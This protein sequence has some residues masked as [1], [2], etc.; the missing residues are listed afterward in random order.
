[1]FLVLLVVTVFLASVAMSLALAHVLELPGKM[2]LNKETYIAVQSIYYPGFTIGGLGE[3]V[4][5]L[6][7]LGLLLMTPAK[8]TAFWCTLTGLTALIAMQGVY[9]LVTH[10][11][12]KF[13]LKDEQLKGLGAGFFSLDPMKLG[14]VAGRAVRTGRG[15]ATSGSIL[16]SLAPAC[17]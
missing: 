4:G 5:M 1:M 8:T 12:N 17:R 15:S 6:A 7:A 9:W 10:P 2:R 16:M 13:W 14:A 3:G 11:V